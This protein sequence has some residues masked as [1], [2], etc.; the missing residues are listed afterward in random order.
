MRKILSYVLVLGLLLCSGC[1]KTNKNND[2]ILA[3]FDAFNNTLQVDSA[4]INGQLNMEKSNPYAI[5][6]D[7]SF[8][9][10]EQIQLALSTDI[11]AESNKQE[12]YLQFYIKD[13]KTYLNSM[14]TKTQSTIDKIGL[15]EN[16]TISMINPFLSF[17]DEQLCQFFTSSKKEGNHSA[18]T[19][20][21]SALASLL[22][23]LGTLTINDATIEC[24]IKDD[25]LENA[26][27]KAQGTQKIN[28][29][30]FDF[31]MT[32]SLNVDQINSLDTINFPDDL[33]TYQVQ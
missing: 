16:S 15:N 18:Y 29:D 3:F 6:I 23:S 13:G 7:L 31:I 19:I 14:G 10:K 20:D 2:D 24:D 26:V 5:D 17:T 11:A 25:V 32:I 27:L 9:Q 33:D 22:D 12:E 4:H 30:S 1:S 28:E 8:N 21:T